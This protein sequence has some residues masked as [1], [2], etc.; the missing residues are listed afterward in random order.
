MS[1]EIAA[2]KEKQTELEAQL[3]ERKGELE[4]AKTEVEESQGRVSEAEAA[5]EEG[6]AA[7][8]E[9]YRP[10]PTVLRSDSSSQQSAAYPS[11]DMRQG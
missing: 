3:E 1:D 8:E 7:L 2:L 11:L 9:M 10:P 5:L 4:T 6:N